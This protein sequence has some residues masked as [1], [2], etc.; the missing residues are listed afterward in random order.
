MILMWLNNHR[1]WDDIISLP[2]KNPQHITNLNNKN[3]L[4]RAQGLSIVSALR[5]A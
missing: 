5:Y 3:L 1:P 4:T 2:S